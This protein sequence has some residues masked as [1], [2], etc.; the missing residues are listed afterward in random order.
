MERE[1]LESEI[2]LQKTKLALKQWDR[3]QADMK[4]TFKQM[5]SLGE[6]VFA[7][8][9]EMLKSDLKKHKNKKDKQGKSWVTI[10]LHL[11]AI[12]S[13]VVFRSEQSSV[14]HLIDNQI[15]EH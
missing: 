1:T 3:I 6:N 2:T 4:D 7:V 9:R 14:A 8:C 10:K 15:S 11:M 13:G 12:S 5:E